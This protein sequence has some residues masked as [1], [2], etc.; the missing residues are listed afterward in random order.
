MLFWPSFSSSLFL[1]GDKRCAFRSVNESMMEKRVKVSNDVQ[2]IH[3]SL[4][5]TEAA[6][7]LKGDLR[8]SHN[9]INRTYFH[10]CF[11][12]KHNL[13]LRRESICLANTTL[14]LLTISR[15][16]FFPRKW[17]RLSQKVPFPFI[18]SPSVLSHRNFSGHLSLAR[19][20]Q[21]KNDVWGHWK[22]KW[23]TPDS[24]WNHLTLNWMGRH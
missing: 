21:T 3:F 17:A 2:R 20:A 7:S 15:G 1:N 13:Q 24:R 5:N 6:H 9:C 16:I 18:V 4:W 8:R 19:A 14:S 11:V 12:S 23:T 22:I 10:I